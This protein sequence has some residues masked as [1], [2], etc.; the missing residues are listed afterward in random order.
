MSVKERRSGLVAL[1]VGF[2]VLVAITAVAWLAFKY[3]LQWTIP[4]IQQLEPNQ[5]V[6]VVVGAGCLILVARSISSGLSHSRQLRIDFRARS[7]RE[8]IYS[9]LAEIWLN[10]L[11]G[12]TDF[13]VMDDKQLTHLE[14]K[15]LMRANPVVLQRYAIFREAVC[16]QKVHPEIAKLFITAVM[17]MRQDIGLSPDVDHLGMANLLVCDVGAS[18]SADQ[19]VLMEQAVSRSSVEE[20]RS[21][22]F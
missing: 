5:M 1:L 12:S 7:G 21:G 20:H 11:R 8:D 18:R 17:E 19:G 16:N 10:Y 9:R 14:S 6:A 2:T 15:L 13:P 4:L 3:L 22:Y